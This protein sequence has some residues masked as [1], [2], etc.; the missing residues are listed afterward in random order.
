MR[1]EKSTRAYEQ[2]LRRHI[3]LLDGDLDLKH[4]RMAEA[5]FP[6]FRA[7][8]Y[9][10]AETWSALCPDLA[11]APTILA[12][13]DLHVEN[14]GTWRDADGRLVWGVNDF[15]EAYPLP[16]TNDLLRL[17]TSAYLASGAT[18]LAISLKD[19]CAAILAGYA[20][21]LDSGGLPFVLEENHAWLHE[22]ATGDLREP[23]AFWA[24]LSSL[25]PLREAVPKTARKAL[26]RM[27]PER[28]LEFDIFH[29]T[30]GMGSLG[31]QR[32]LALASWRGGKVAREA[33]ALAP[34]ACVFASNGRATAI[35]YADIIAQAIRVPDPFVRM[36]GRWIVRRLAPHCTRVELAA[37]PKV[38]DEKRLLHAM[39]FETANIHL[40]APKARKR[41]A[42]DL[43]KRRA[44]WL[45]AAVHAMAEAVQ[46]DW[47]AWRE[48]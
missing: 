38:R 28:N 39:G 31:R 40:G 16:Y 34:S 22:A 43:G 27:L 8:Y 48:R 41:I 36:Y 33:K 11:T 24:K 30:A 18:H 44:G 6:F 26:A 9:R 32:F 1:F 12:V 45:P 42:R 2:W 47:Q 46:A 19:A 35:H 15:D 37:L 13:G 23:V 21:A 20:A 25:A 7:T 10:W 17:A 3:T 5:I 29:R 14:F 4:A